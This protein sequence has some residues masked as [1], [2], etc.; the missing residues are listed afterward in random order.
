MYGRAFRIDPSSSGFAYLISNCINL[1]T[2]LNSP[3]A[4]ET[5]VLL[6]LT[7]MEYERW[8]WRATRFLLLGI[9]E[10]TFN[11]L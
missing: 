1:T 10:K 2:G 11:F 5:S 4:N 3:R 8:V 6:L 9:Y 7:L